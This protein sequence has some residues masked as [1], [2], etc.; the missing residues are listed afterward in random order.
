MQKTLIYDDRT[1]NSHLLT[2]SLTHNPLTDSYANIAQIIIFL[3]C[4]NIFCSAFANMHRGSIS[5]TV[6][7]PPRA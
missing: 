3:S 4:Y 2:R 1:L 6:G 5:A 7:F